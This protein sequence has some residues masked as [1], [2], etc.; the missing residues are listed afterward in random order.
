[1]IAIQLLKNVV[2]VGSGKDGGEGEVVSCCSGKKREVVLGLGADEVSL[3]LSSL[4]DGVCLS[5]WRIVVAH[6]MK[7]L[8]SS[9]SDRPVVLSLRFD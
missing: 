1:M 7:G 5:R 6:L 4:V 9:H 8:F 3:G 2:G